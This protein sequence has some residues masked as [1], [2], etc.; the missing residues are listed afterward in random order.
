MTSNFVEGKCVLQ[1]Y[2]THFSFL[3]VTGVTQVS[4]SDMGQG[5]EGGGV[6]FRSKKSY[7][8][9]L[10]KTEFAID[11]VKFLIIL[12]SL[13]ELIFHMILLPE[14]IFWRRKWL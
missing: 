9:S 2:K 3:P 11:N 13:F 14:V 8:P 5:R 1:Y 7:N 4:K 6:I 10:K 12:L